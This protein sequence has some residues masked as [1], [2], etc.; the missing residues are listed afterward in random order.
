MRSPRTRPPSRLGA[1][2]PALAATLAL[3]SCATRISVSEPADPA[4][5]LP[6]EALVY[7]LAGRPVLE[8][9]AAALLAP[10]DL[11]AVRSLLTRTDRV[12]AALVLP[13]DGSGLDGSGASGTESGAGSSRRADLFG[14]AEGTYP[15]GAASFRLRLSRDWRKEGRALV[16]RDGKLRIAFA[17]RHLL[18]AGTS[19]LDPL[20]DRLVDPGPGPLPWDLLPDRDSPGALWIPRPG[21]LAGRI[22]GAEAPA[23]PA[24]GL[25][26]ALSPGGTEGGYTG[27]WIF[28]FDSDR[29]ARVYA[30]LCRLAHLAFIRAVHGPGGEAAASAALERTVWTAE[31]GLVR[32]SGF[33]L[34]VSSLLRALDGFLP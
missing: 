20:L 8:E 31:G 16:R 34:S 13:P 3:S 27:T 21:E 7:I 33:P 25:L 14:I 30:P 11:K 2:A 22:W 23:P 4:A 1:L 28:A 9:A 29:D 5:S 10:A 19:D 18:A 24:R 17:G 15:A 26:L 6:R 12:T 32:A